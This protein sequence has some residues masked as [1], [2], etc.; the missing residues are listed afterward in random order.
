MHNEL[1]FI[2]RWEHCWETLI[3]SSTANYHTNDVSLATKRNKWLQWQLQIFCVEAENKVKKKMGNTKIIKQV[4]YFNKLLMCTITQFTLYI[5][6]MLCILSHYKYWLISKVILNLKPF[7]PLY[8][9]SWLPFQQPPYQ[10]KSSSVPPKTK[11]E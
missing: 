7:Q 1:I 3:W 11:I 10:W 9:T 2:Q 8:E 6:F 5:S 4:L